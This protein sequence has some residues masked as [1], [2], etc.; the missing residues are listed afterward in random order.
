[1]TSASVRLFD[2]ALDLLVPVQCVGCGLQH[3]QLCAA[4]REELDRALP[5]A[6]RPHAAPPGLPEVYAATTY[7]GAAR[8]IL[9][10]HKER[11]ALRL[12][13]PLG[14][15][16]ARAVRAAVPTGGASRSAPL[17]LVPMPSAPATVRARG[18][19]PTR[20]LTLAATRALR[21]AGVPAR[22]LAVLRQQRAV[23]D[24]SELGAAERLRNLSGA[25]TVPRHRRSLLGHGRIVLV[26]DLVTTGAT[27]AE[28]ARALAEAGGDV[29]AAAV[30]A[31]TVRRDGPA[32]EDRPD[33]RRGGRPGAAYPG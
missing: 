22:L 23:A 26:D 24:Q 2:A 9:L 27:L 17:L 28:G 21:R 14:G 5:R 30:V 31:A 6:A 12:A 25:L 18:H 32:P 20:R 29:L 11:G 15:A 10:A 4:C 8:Q 1:M 3:A 7:D 16:L 33:G 19:D 13:H